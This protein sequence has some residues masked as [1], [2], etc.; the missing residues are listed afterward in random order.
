MTPDDH[1]PGRPA[2]RQPYDLRVSLGEKVGETGLRRRWR[3]AT[4]ASST[5]FTTGSAV[6]G[7]GVRAGGL[8]QRLPVPVRL[9][10]QPR[11]LEDDQRDARHL[12]AGVEV[13]GQYRH[14]LQHHEGRADD[15]RR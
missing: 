8:A 3:A 11:H 1:E 6:D 9:L 4:G 5:R 15:Q 13:V 14:S 2:H 12:D 10:P 7:P